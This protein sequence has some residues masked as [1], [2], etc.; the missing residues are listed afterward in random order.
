MRF[1]SAHVP[2]RADRFVDRR[3]EVF[4]HLR[5]ALR[6]GRLALPVDEKL[7][8]EPVTI[9]WRPDLTARG[10]IR[11][12]RKDNLRRRLGRSPDRADAVAMCLS[13]VDVPEAVGFAFTP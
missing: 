6:D 1:N 9:R 11:V 8:D 12:E 5:E 7:A 3:A 10:R 13:G 2:R 4:W